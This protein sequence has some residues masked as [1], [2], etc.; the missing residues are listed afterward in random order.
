[1]DRLAHTLEGN[2]LSC[3]MTLSFQYSSP[4]LPK[5]D[6]ASQLNELVT[7]QILMFT[8]NSIPECVGCHL[9]SNSCWCSFP[10]KK[11]F[12][13]G[14]F[15]NSLV[16]RLGAGAASLS[17]LLQYYVQGF[18]KHWCMELKQQEVG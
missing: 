4:K 11:F 2:Q 5:E 18:K 13:D 6:T 3:Q 14:M 17:H 8:T 16:K 12:T 9:S 15:N 7:N 10:P 1:M